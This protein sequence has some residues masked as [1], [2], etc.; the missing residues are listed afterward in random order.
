MVE[1]LLDLIGD[2]ALSRL[3]LKLFLDKVLQDDSL[4]QFFEGVD[5]ARPPLPAG[6]VHFNAPRR[7]SVYR[8]EYS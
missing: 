1:D 7:T 6:H 8:E 3:L 5:M 4:R 2:V